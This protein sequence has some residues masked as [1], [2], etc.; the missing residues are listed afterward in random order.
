LETRV[1]GSEKEVVIG[2]GLPTVIIG[3]RINPAANK[4][5]NQALTEGGDFEEIV[6]NEATT[7]V[8][9]G[10][11]MIDINISAFGVDEVSLLPKA[12]KAAQEV[13]NVPLCIDSN[14]SDA[15]AAALKVYKG[16]PLVNSVSGETPSITKVLPMIK[17]YGAAVVGLVQ[18]D[19][20]VP[21]DA[22]RRL[23]VAN[24][25]LDTAVKAGIPREDVLIDC[26]AFAVGA[27]TDSGPEVLKAIQRV[28]DE[29]GLN[30]TLGASNISF[31]LP[32]REVI[33]TAFLP[34]IVE[35]GVTCLITSAKKAIPVV[36]AIDLILARD[37]RARRYMESYRMR[38]A[39]K[40]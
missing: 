7:Q 15:I 25:I 30:Q 38:A 19:E 37:K 24:K 40:K 1:T 9:L 34:M 14:N 4:K 31:G 12:V 32:D 18:D 36:R 2:H 10:A 22:D 35:K 27:D 39:A 28:R 11:D 20:G 29:L 8:N 26:L 23:V 6:R 33:N 16:K 13:V 3:E 21:K 17:E 5:L